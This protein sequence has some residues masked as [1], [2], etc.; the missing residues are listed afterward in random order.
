MRYKFEA[1]PGTVRTA[2]YDVSANPPA[3]GSPVS[4][5]VLTW[6]PSVFQKGDE[7]SAAITGILAGLGG[8]VL[9]FL[10]IF[11]M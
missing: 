8:L 4:V 10:G 2:T 7:V 9:L 11:K 1:P 3:V 5:R 6:D